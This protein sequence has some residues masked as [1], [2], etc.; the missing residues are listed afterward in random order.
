MNTP[1]T[2][3]FFVGYL[4]MPPRLK[5]FVLV[6]SSALLLASLVFA[7]VTAALRDSPAKSTLTPNVTLV[8]R[9]EARAYGLLWTADD[10]GTV[11]PVLLAR[12]GKLGAPDAV[13]KLDG[14]LARMTGL[15]LERDGYRLLEVANLT[16][17]PTLEAS[18]QRRL[19][20][21]SLVDGGS[22]RLRGEIVDIKC[23]LGR[24]KPGDG[25]THRACAQFCIA[26]GIP[27]VLV[28]RDQAGV[29]RRY[30]LT[31]MDG[32]PVNDA[33]LP[34][35]AEAVELEGRLETAPGMSFLRID[36]ARIQRL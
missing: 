25:R 34:Y 11:R 6:V 18:Q 3:D 7:T 17:A 27:P 35:V 30:L 14:K 28:S 10:D 5:R 22:L 23:W 36:P 21:T 29:E 19:A 24:M 31:S 26:G 32:G 15:L 8:G 9:V 4:P 12:G 16:P 20:Q 33:V 2:D 13:R 1:E